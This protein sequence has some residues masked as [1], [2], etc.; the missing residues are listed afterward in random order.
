MKGAGITVGVV[1]AIVF[2]FGCFSGVFHRAGRPDRRGH[3]L[4]KIQ[5]HDAGRF[6]LAL[7]VPDSRAMKSSMCPGAYRRS[8]L[9]L[10]RQATSRPKESLML[11]ED[12]N[13]IDIQFAV[14][15]KLKNAVAWVF[16]N[17]DPEE[18]VQPG[19]RNVDPRNR[20]PQ[21]DGFRAVR[22]PRE[23]GAR[24]YPDPD[25]ADPGPL[26]LGRANDQCDDAGRAAAGAGAGRIRR[27]RQGRSGPRA[28]EER[29]PGL[30]QR[31]DSE[32]ARRGVPPDAGSRSL[33]RAD[34]ANRDGD[35]RAS[36]RC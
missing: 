18:T 15:Y 28:P 34:R 3:H 17:R 22:R 31:R 30:C 26:P 21:Q 24:R 33:S 25:A 10:Q 8:R 5:P 1:A 32:S 2:F 27:C 20:R 35:A 4:R 13:I 12:E 14:Q 16:N 36:S 29:R 23:S 6:Q 9:P 7:A 19:R 11:T